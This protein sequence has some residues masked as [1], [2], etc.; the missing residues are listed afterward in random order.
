M[1]ALITQVSMA[2]TWQTVHDFQYV[3][4]QDAVNFGL[5][6]APSG[7]I[8]A[9]GYASDGSIERGLVMAGTDGGTSWSMALD[10]FSVPGMAVPDDGGIV[11]DLV[12]NLYVWTTSP[13]WRA[14]SPPI[15]PAMPLSVARVPGWYGGINSGDQ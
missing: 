14:P 6:V 12:G 11:P 15:I 9:S 3:A 7:V 1:L 10:D 4:G 2:Q 8:F 5:A 13:A